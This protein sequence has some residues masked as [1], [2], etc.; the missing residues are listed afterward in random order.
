MSNIEGVTAI[1]GQSECIT[2]MPIIPFLKD[3][4]TKVV[5]IFDN[6]ETGIKNSEELAQKYNVTNFII[7]PFEGGKDI[8]DCF[9]QKKFNL[10]KEKWQN[11]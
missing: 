2:N 10:I 1:C 8:S 6:D 11:I 7:P 3:L 5:I 4:Y 9:K